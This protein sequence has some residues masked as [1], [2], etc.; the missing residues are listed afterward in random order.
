MKTYFTSDTHFNHTNIAGPKVSVWNSGY[1]IFDSVEEMNETL[2]NNWNSK[3]KSDDV[4]YHLG[5]VGFAT[6]ELLKPILRRLNGKIYLC[7]GNHEKAALTDGNNSRFEAVWDTRMIY[8]NGQQIWLSHYAHRVWD[9]SHDG[10]W[11]LYGHS[12]GSLPDDPES[13]SFDIGVDCHNYFPLEFEEV[14]AIMSQKTYKPVDH[15][16]R[17]GNKRIKRT[18]KTFTSRSF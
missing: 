17:T 2:I 4:V 18:E 14:A 11:H 3:I 9:R 15:H 6:A 13:L 7:R 8:V 16:D 12:H 1:R 5:D 10:A